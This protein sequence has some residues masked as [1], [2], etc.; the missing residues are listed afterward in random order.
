MI[1]IKSDRIITPDGLFDGYIYFDGE[2]ILSVSKQEQPCDLLHD[3][4][5]RYVSPGFIDMHVHGGNGADF[6][7]AEPD[8][9][10]WAADF[11]LRHG[12][13]TILP[14]VTSVTF[15]SKGLTS[16]KDE[17]EDE[18]ERFRQLTDPYDD[19]R[20]TAGEAYKRM[21]EEHDYVAQESPDIITPAIQSGHEK[22]MEWIADFAQVEKSIRKI[23]IHNPTHKNMGF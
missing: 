9:V 4:T 16:E 10:A 11:H 8:K 20:L 21:Q 2:K 7:K 6:C 5:G 3:F 23:D 18:I 19:E 17:F 15:D 22:F 14:T 1:G 13:T 12:T